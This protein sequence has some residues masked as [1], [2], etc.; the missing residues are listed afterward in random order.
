ML[1]ALAVIPLAF[2]SST[3]NYGLN[4]LS[5][6][7]G[8][9]LT[10]LGVSLTVLSGS[11]PHMDW[12]KADGASANAA[13]IIATIMTIRNYKTIP[14]IVLGF[15]ISIIVTFVSVHTMTKDRVDFEIQKTLK[16]GGCVLLK[17]YENQVVY[18]VNDIPFGFVIGHNS[19]RIEFVM[20]ETSSKWTYG[21]MKTI[22]SRADFKECLNKYKAK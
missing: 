11:A 4:V 17:D 14:L 8:F 20:R 1:I 12:I 16:S 21:N 9:V 22:P 5:F 2:L 7:I 15:L 19:P 18:N 6:L 10:F 13:F 3:K